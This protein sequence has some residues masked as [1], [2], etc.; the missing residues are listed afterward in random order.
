L[1]AERLAAIGQ[2]MAALA[3]EGRNALQRSHAFL[4]RLGWKLQDQPEERDL[5]ARA[6][7]AQDDLTRLFRD[8]QDFAKPVRLDGTVCDLSEVWQSAWR[9]V[10]AE[11]TDRDARLCEMIRTDSLYCYADPFHLTQV[12]RNIFENSLAACPEPVLVEV[13]CSEAE[14]EGR[15]ALRVAVRDNGPGLSAEQRRR[16]FE[17]FY[18]TKAKGTGLGMAIAKRVMEAHDGRIAVGPGGGAGAEIVITLPR[19]RP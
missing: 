19:S 17:P 15:P 14:C 7:K 5:V 2:T 10:A 9:E 6:Q 1:Q 13:E 4:E 11:R 3:H 12:F 16:I 8:I 18:T